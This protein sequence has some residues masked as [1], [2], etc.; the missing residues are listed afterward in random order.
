MIAFDQN[1][2]LKICQLFKKFLTNCQAYAYSMKYAITC[3]TMFCLPK[4]A[5]CNQLKTLPEMK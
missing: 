1:R 4:M 5:F 2:K 3:K